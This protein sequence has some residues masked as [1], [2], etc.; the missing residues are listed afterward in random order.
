[1]EDKEEVVRRIHELL[2][3][4]GLF[5]SVTACFKDKSSVSTMV[6]V[7]LFLLLKKLGMFPL[8][9][10]RFTSKDVENLMTG[11][12]FKIIESEMIDDGISA[13]FIIA[14]KMKNEKRKMKNEK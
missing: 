11:H 6:Q 3:P 10:N 7:Y 12:H 4:G 14:Q 8:H 13:S 1:L 2:K 5:I 9:L